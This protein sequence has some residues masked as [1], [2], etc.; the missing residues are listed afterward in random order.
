MAN[1]FIVRKGLIVEGASGGTVVDIQGSQGQLFSVTDDLSGSIF[2]V[3]DISGVP[4]FDVNSSGVS[5][6]DGNVGIGT[7]NA[8]SKLTVSEV[9]NGNIA[10]FTNTTDADLHINLT[11]GVTMLT[12]TTALLAFGTSS[13]E[14]MRII[15]NGNVGIGTTDPVSKLQVQG[16]IAL[17]N[18]GVIG[19]GSAYGNPGN[20][21]SSTLSLYDSATGATILNNQSYDIRLNTGGGNKF[22]V[23]NGGNVGI[24]TTNPAYKLDVDGSINSTSLYVNAVAQNSGIRYSAP[25]N[26][27]SFA[28]TSTSDE[29]FKIIAG[30]GSPATHRISI[31]SSGDN[32]NMADEYLVNTAGYGMNMHIQRLP[33]VRYNTSKLAAIAAV[34]PS[35][36]GNTEV[37]IKLLGMASGSGVTVIAS[38]TTIKTSAEILA[39]ATT[40]APTLTSNDTQLDITT[41]NRNNATLM[42]S[43]G[44]TFGGNVG[45]GTTSPGSKLEIA[46]A[47]STTNATALFSIQK[48]EEGYGLF[49]GLYGSGASWLQ[50]GTADGTTDYS[51]VM[52]PNGGN[53]GIGVTAP[54]SAKLHVAGSVRA[55]SGVY[56]NST[57]TLGFKIEND[58][59]NNELD[60]YGGAL[61][62]AITLTNSGYIKFGNYGLSGAGGVPVKLLGL[63]SNQNVVAANTFSAT[64][65]DQLPTADGDASGTIVNWTVSTTTTA[66]LLYVVISSGGWQTTDADFE[67]RSI[68]MLGIALS[69]DADEGMLLQGFFYKAA[70]GFTIGLP[71]YISNTS[72]AFTTTRPTGTN[73]YVRIIGYATSANY[74]YFDPDKTWIKLT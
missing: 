15:G 22:I 5:Y 42:T 74:I 27:V 48:N 70:H 34:N 6:F 66:G 4:I 17:A 33:G 9:G 61:V 63:D 3:S 55:T 53:V 59:S 54:V 13:S 24:G 16:D 11:S 21:A 29:W 58:F 18:N 44:A 12:P 49:S 72:G 39:S 20:S 40:T 28:R 31:T 69:T 64:I 73:D 65:D 30:G 1:E 43:R 60:L 7:T 57:S 45:I 71:L 38:N 52:Q 68:G 35:N 26:K 8:S 46:G 36:G 25:N 2:A 37:W 32:T 14:K 19:Q 50:S 62:P 56:F 10:L 47:N 67:L 23:K 41:D 51:I